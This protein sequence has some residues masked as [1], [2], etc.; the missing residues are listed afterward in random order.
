[1]QALSARDELEQSGAAAGTAAIAPAASPTSPPASSPE[2]KNNPQTIDEAPAGRLQ[3]ERELNN[4]VPN[5]EQSGTS[6]DDAA[7]RRSSQGEG[8]VVEG[9]G[10][11]EREKELTLLRNVVE[12]LQREVEGLKSDLEVRVVIISS[13]IF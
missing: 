10:R 4:A 9:R 13:E 1:M 11:E 3:H 8:G 2:G 5:I 12:K 6:I 7:A